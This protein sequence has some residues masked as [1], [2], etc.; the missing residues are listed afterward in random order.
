MKTLDFYQKYD[1]KI[2]VIL[3]FFDC[4]H[5]GH[6][7]LIGKGVEIAKSI[8]AT[9]AVFTFANDINSVF[10][11]SDGLVLTFSERL[12]KLEKHSINTVITCDFNDNFVSLGCDEFL[13][14]LTENFD[15]GAIVCGYDYTYGYR[16]QGNVESLKSYFEN[17]A[18]KVVSLNPV[19]CDGERV[20]TTMIK[21]RLALG[22]IESAN[23]LLVDHYFLRGEVVEGRKDGR[24]I[25]FPTANIF[26]PREKFRIKSGVYKTRVIVDGHTYAAITNYGSQPTFN[27]FD[28]V[29][30]SH[31]KSFSR[32]V[33][34]KV[35][36][37][38]FDGF[39]RDIVKFSDVEDLRLQLKKDLEAFEDD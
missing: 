31:I 36:T 9:P 16:A 15:V 38:I 11:K 33:Y 25:G 37:V 14:K 26:L 3:G 6:L 13:D 7:A 28:V 24:K 12:K 10:S 35:I 29:V 27:Q 8:G 17:S 30:E 20:S 39:I 5:V 2:V 4:I 21:K 18:V 32:D 19:L 23:R 22:E 34:G 1:G